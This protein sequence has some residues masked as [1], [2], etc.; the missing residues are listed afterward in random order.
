MFI[1]NFLQ[2]YECQ[3]LL[4]GYYFILMGK[5]FCE[6][7][8]NVGWIDPLQEA[9]RFFYSEAEEDLC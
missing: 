4:S 8:Y 5:F 7:D 1:K 3:V 9:D 6:K 2:C